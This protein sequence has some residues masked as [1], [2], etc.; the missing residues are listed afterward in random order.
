MAVGAFVL[1]LFSLLRSDTSHLAGPS[2]L[3]G[4]FLL[5][6]PV[7]LWRCLAPG[8]ARTVLLVVSLAVIA[9]GAISGAG[10]VERRVAGLGGVWHDSAA[11]LEL[12]DELRSH[13]SDVSD[14]AGLYSPLPRVQAA[15]RNHPDFAEAEEFF[16]LLR[17]RL[18]GRPVELGSYRF[19]DLVAHPDTA[20]FLGGL[21]SLSGIT[22][23]KNSLWLRSEQEAW[24][25]RVASTRSGCLFFNADSNWDLVDAWMS[26][27]K[28]P[29]TMAIEPI[30]GRREYGI[31]ACKSG[32]RS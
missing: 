5:M 22:S 9:E 14:L 28:P 10:E 13:R 25:A 23:P 16:G 26:S 18:E 7:F 30:A 17:E 12:Y 1:H 29:Q 32:A 4:P 2:F 3:L 11:V 8:K 19:N 15:F 27:V 24:I 21:R 6:L 31:L 20:Y